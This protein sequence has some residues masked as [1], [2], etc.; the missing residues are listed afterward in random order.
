MIISRTSYQSPFL[1][2]PYILILCKNA[3]S[4]CLKIFFST[5]FCSLIQ[6]IFPLYLCITC[7]GNGYILS[8]GKCHNI[9]A[10]FHNV[11]HIY[12]KAQVRPHKPHILQF[13]FQFIQF[14]INLK[15][16]LFC[17]KYIFMPLCFYINDV[18]YMKFLLFPLRNE[19]QEFYCSFLFLQ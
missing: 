18:V 17:V 13:I 11:S 16:A 14:F 4:V 19:I 10:D 7:L 12:K 8:C 15:C 5:L 1:Y 6:H 3:N 2:F 9:T